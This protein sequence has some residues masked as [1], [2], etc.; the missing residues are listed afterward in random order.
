MKFNL[1]GRGINH[2]VDQ[3]HLQSLLYPES[4]STT[5]PCRTIII[6]ADV[7]HPTGSARPGCP[8]IAAVVGS[9]DDNY[10]HYPGSMRLQ[11]PKQEFITD[12]RDMVKERLIDWALKHQSNLPANVLMYRD[13]VSESQYELVRNGEIPQLQEA[14]NDAYEYFKGPGSAKSNPPKFKLTFVVVEKRHNT[15][16]F[17]DN[18]TK[19]ASF[20][21]DVSPK[22]AQNDVYEGIQDEEE[23]EFKEKLNRDGRVMEGKWTR[24]NHNLKPGFVVDKVIT[25]PYREGFFLQSHKPLQGTGRSA[26]YF[27][28]RNQMRLDSDVLQKV[29]HALCYVYTRATK[30]VFYCTP[31]YYA[32]RLCDR[33]RAWFREYLTGHRSIQQRE[34]EDFVAFK[35][36]ALAAYFRSF[37][38]SINMYH[39]HQPVPSPPSSPDR[40][41]LTVGFSALTTWLCVA[42]ARLS[43]ASQ[44]G[45]LPLIFA[46]FRD[47]ITPCVSFR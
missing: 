30:G 42:L 3:D 39:Y 32:D 36:R 34:K 21:S 41:R 6:G 46:A 5:A 24:H 22:D 37:P 15:R 10:L 17:T 33:G 26:H 20:L 11:L 18:D 7:A 40:N 19:D 16:F 45:W 12:L 28:L 2:S 47:W 27:V 31:A 8:S 9:V 38:P 43:L 25:H 29:T 35:Q 1:K 23:Q 14:F 4:P 13:G 44:S